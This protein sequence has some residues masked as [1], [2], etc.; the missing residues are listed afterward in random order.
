MRAPAQPIIT[1]RSPEFKNEF[2][3]GCLASAG[4]HQKAYCACAVQKIQDNFTTEEF[5]Q[6]VQQ[7]QQTGMMQSPLV[8]KAMRPC[9][10]HIVR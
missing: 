2:M 7:Y 8:E 1:I 6:Q 9:F 10:T 4:A 5:V 3:R